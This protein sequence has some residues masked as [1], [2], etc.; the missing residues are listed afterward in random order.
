VLQR[1]AIARIEN[2]TK[3][4]IAAAIVGPEN[5]SKPVIAAAVGKARAKWTEL[6]AD[7]GIDELRKIADAHMADYMKSTTHAHL[8]LDLSALT[9][10]RPPRSQSA[11]RAWRPRSAR[12]GR[13]RAPA[14][15]GTSGR[16]W[17]QLDLAGRDLA[18]LHAE[19]DRRPG[20]HRPGEND[21]FIGGQVR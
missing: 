2:P 8:Y 12:L 13:V 15:T 19:D 3:P 4:N 14:G 5:L 9:V 6:T 1:L 17:R 18:G 21:P 11:A 10:T 20:A 7:R 16:S